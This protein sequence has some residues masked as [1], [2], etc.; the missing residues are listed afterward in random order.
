MEEELI[1]K[2]TREI[3]SVV[4][5][6]YKE[7]LTLKTDNSRYLYLKSNNIYKTI[8][9]SNNI[10]DINNIYLELITKL[11]YIQNEYSKK[12]KLY[13]LNKAEEIKKEL[14][15]L[16][17]EGNL[18]VSFLKVITKYKTIKKLPSLNIESK[19]KEEDLENDDKLDKLNSKILELKEKAT[20]LEDEEN[21]EIYKK[22]NNLCI[23]RENYIKNKTGYSNISLLREIESLETRVA[24]SKEIKEIKPYNI[25]SDEYSIVLK[26]TINALANLKFYGM[27]SKVFL[28]DDS[29]SKEENRNNFDELYR[30][31]I[32][33]YTNLIYSLYQTDDVL[34]KISFNETISSRELISLLSIYNLEGKYENF[35]KK[36][37]E[38]KIDGYNINEIEYVE[39]CIYIKKAINNLCVSSSSLINKKFGSLVVSNFVKGKS[40]LL[41][42]LNKKY[43]E[44]NLIVKEK[45]MNNE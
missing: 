12:I 24:M 39:K 44:L 3:F 28:Y 2:L 29:I 5:Y 26:N 35:I 32:N 40:E 14:I 33:K 30:D 1:Y 15:I 11:N 8:L 10:N 13:K 16:K 41:E 6:Y 45:E 7:Y 31:Y 18:C 37:R 34:I 21:L 22:I 42:E 43:Q 27:E 19:E 17:E 38:N 25:S 9:E 23:E 4:E 36:H 20:K